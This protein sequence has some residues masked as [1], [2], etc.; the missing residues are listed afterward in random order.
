MKAVDFILV[1]VLGLLLGMVGT[2][3]LNRQ[4]D[5][6]PEYWIAKAKYDQ[7]VKDA[8]AQHKA[9]LQAVA[10]AQSTIDAQSAHIGDLLAEAQKPS[11][12]EKEKDKQIAQLQTQVAA[13]EAQ[14]DLAAALAASKAESKAWASKYSLAVGMH[15][16]SLSALNKAWQAKFDAQAQ[17][18]NTWKAAYEQENTLRLAAESI[19]GKLT[20]Q[21]K[22]TKAEKW[23]QRAGYAVAFVLGNLSHR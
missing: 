21:A 20:K 23:V 3:L 1:L 14:G 11:P 8:D 15:Q 16:E 9:D 2:C 22:K 10:D 5:P 7:A 4:G 6:D 17:A 13:Y 18:L 12:A 19:V